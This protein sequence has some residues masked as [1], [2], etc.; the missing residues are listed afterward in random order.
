ML[1]SWT[2]IQTAFQSLKALQMSVGLCFW[3]LA[4]RSH[5]AISLL[6]SQGLILLMK[7]VPEGRVICNE[8]RLLQ[9]LWA[10]RWLDDHFSQMEEIK[11]RGCGV[12][13]LNSKLKKQ[14]DTLQNLLAS[15]YNQLEPFQGTLGRGG[16]LDHCCENVVHRVLILQQVNAKH[17]PAYKENDVGLSKCLESKLCITEITNRRYE[18]YD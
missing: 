3:P 12:K 15:V 4:V 7:N 8:R 1:G 17:S 9:A 16:G 11:A 5:W 18:R 13:V 10:E 6:Y 14:L 2:D